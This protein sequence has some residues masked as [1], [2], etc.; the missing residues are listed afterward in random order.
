MKLKHLWIPAA[1]GGAIGAA[2][3]E[4]DP[5]VMARGP[6]QHLLSLGSQPFDRYRNE[7]AVKWALAGALVGLAV[8]ALIILASG[9]RR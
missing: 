7:L 2:L 9:K 5:R 8:G 3:A 6:W 4:Y 1:L